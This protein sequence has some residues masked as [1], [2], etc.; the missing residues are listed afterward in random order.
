MIVGIED[1]GSGNRSQK[2][3][4]SAAVFMARGIMTNWK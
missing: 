2:I 1:F 4:T 3:A